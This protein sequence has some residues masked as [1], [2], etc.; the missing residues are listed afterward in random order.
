MKLMRKLTWLAATN[1]FTFSSKHIPGVTNVIID[2]LSRFDFQT[3][4]K[5]APDA[6]VQATTCPHYSLVM[7][8]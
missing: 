4:L 5:E 7:W 1:N 3:F 2:A 8:N 6:D